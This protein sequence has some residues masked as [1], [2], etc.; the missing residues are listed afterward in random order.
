MFN[1]TSDN[2]ANAL[3]NNYIYINE[4]K[5][6]LT[7]ICPICLDP[8]IDPQTHVLCENSFCNLCI[9][10]LRHCPYCRTSI[11]ELNDLNTTSPVLRNILDELQVRI[12][13]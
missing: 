13:E 1:V 7:L 3:A 5:I 6:S 12:Y 11:M 9:R 4:D 10:K 8:L 2:R